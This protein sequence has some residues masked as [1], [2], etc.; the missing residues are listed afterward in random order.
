MKDFKED[1]VDI[2]V[3]DITVLHYEKQSTGFIRPAGR[4]LP[5]HSEQ[6]FSRVLHFLPLDPY[7]LSVLEEVVYSTL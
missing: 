4:T 6:E 1:G 5:T 7:D 2:V 3:S